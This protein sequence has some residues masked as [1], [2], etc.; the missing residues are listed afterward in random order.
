MIGAS[1]LNIDFAALRTMRTVF[2][3][4]SFTAAA[5]ELG[6]NQS[7]ISYTIERLRRAFDDPLFVRLRGKITATDRCRELMVTVNQIWIDTERMVSPKAFDPAKISDSLAI[8]A[9][10]LSRA[11]IMPRVIQKSSRAAPGLR[12]V[13]NAG[14]ASAKQ[15]LLDGIVDIALTPVNIKES[16]VHRKV[17]FED[18]YVCA[19]AFDHELA[20]GD[21][22][23]ERYAEARHLVVNYGQAW[24]PLYLRELR[25]VGIGIRKAVTTAD[26]A[27]IPHM[28]PGTDLIAAVPA[29]IARQF[30]D[31]IAIRPCPVRA[32]T[33]IKMYW[34]AR[35]DKSPLNTWFR[36]LVVDAVD[37]I[38][39]K[40]AAPMR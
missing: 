2:R 5:D 16:G 25:K 35:S 36:N 4:K 29:W 38:S 12:L 32:S 11:A 17:L 7:T 8:S 20:K 24:E 15:D 19:M 37:E 6:V 28:L 34:T 40:F 31:R 13:L 18:S 23:L 30:A 9:T 33:A 3:L 21:L 14:F 1:L 10:F 27:D 22:T 39:E 26:P